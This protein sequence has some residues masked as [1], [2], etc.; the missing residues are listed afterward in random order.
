MTGW[1]DAESGRC[2]LGG[3]GHGFVGQD[4][5]LGLTRCPRCR[6]HKCVADLDRNAI[7]QL[8]LLAVGADDAGRSQGIE[9]HPLGDRGQPG[10]EGG[11][12]IA[13]V[14]NRPQGVHKP[15]PTR[16]VEC[17]ELWHWPVA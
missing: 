3:G 7:G 8:A 1:V 5:T 13:G 4:H 6:H 16:E 12:R 15:H 9:Q 10:V 14:P 11:R 2:G 17:N